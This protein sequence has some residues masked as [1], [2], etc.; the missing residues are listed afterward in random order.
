[1][2]GTNTYA[3][4]ST[5]AVIIYDDNALKSLDYGINFLA[6]V[7]FWARVSLNANYRLGLANIAEANYKWSDTIK[8]RVFALGVGVAL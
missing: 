4:G 1:M 8:N 2:D 7:I 6:G 3:S 5:T